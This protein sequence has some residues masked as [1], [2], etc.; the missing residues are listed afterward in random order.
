MANNKGMAPK[1]SPMMQHYLSMK[2]DYPDT[3][4]MYR[5]GDFYE[6]FF[7]DALEVSKLLDLTLTGRDCGLKERAPMCGVPYHAADNYIGKLVKLGKKV[8]I[9]EQLSAPGDQKGMVKR[10]VIRVITPGTVTSD[11]L[12]DSTCNNY[13]LS[14]FINNQSGAL[15][16]LDVSTGEMKVEELDENGLNRIEDFILSISPSEIIG[17]S[18]GCE[19]IKYSETVQTGKLPKPQNYYNYAFDFDNAAKTLRE[20]YSIYN[21]AA[22][23]MEDARDAVC[24]A[25]ALLNYIESTQKRTLS[26]IMTPRLMRDA[27]QMFLDY[28]TKRNLELT[29]TLTDKS[30]IGSLLWVL[31]K[32]KTNMGGR[33]LRRWIQEP[34]QNAEEIVFRQTAVGELVKNN[35]LRA[36]LDCVL[37]GIRDVERLCNKL[38]Y[39]SINPRE[40]LSVAYSLSQIP[41]LKKLLSKAKTEYLKQINGRLDPLEPI[42]ELI[43]KAINEQAPPTLKDGGVIQNG[44]HEELDG[45]RL[46]RSNAKKWLAEY[47]AR[48]R[49]STGLKTLKLGFNNVFGYYIE[50]SNSYLNLVP[51]SYERKQTLSTGERFITPELKKME[52]LILGAEEKAQKLEEKLYA[53]IKEVL[54]RAIKPLQANARAVAELDALFSFACSAYENAYVCPVI[55]KKNKHIL[56]KNGRHPVVEALKKA[57]EF[58]PNDTVMD[59]TSR[60]LIVT[61]PNMAGK[62][63]YMRQ[64][65][66]IVLMAH[67]GSFVPADS[68]EICLVDRIFTR[69]GASDNL[70]F[71]QS[72]FMVEMTEVANILNN[73]TARSLLILDEIGRGT[74][75]LDGLS[76]AWAIVEHVSLKL[77]AKTLFATHY[78]ELSELETVI[79]DLK[80]YHVLIKEGK[81]GIT[82]LYKIA[83]GGASKSFGIEVASLAGVSAKVIERAKDIMKTLEESHALSGG[84]HEKITANA[85]QDAIPIDQMGFFAEENKVADEIVSILEDVHVDEMTPVQALTL[86]SDLKKKLPNKKTKGN[87][88]K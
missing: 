64:V 19:R 27:G 30:R 33:C 10:D 55:S 17:N 36:E 63:T 79:P 60:T 61:G 62:S 59:D 7:E 34:L 8:S 84:F 70:A 83:R 67:M 46:A 52:E 28:N 81:D 51:Y 38:A 13:I 44:Y 35:S 12:L 68:A 14:I 2:K 4:L 77:K 88:S 23:G 37:G 49:E 87:R 26:H 5:L 54:A 11:E 40:C 58:V 57:N 78:H 72:T 65:A 85:S 1:L 25:G 22:I 86:L 39:N 48:E 53:D 18:E 9:C 56:I 45:Y 41:T 43:K 82:F 66:L 74:S 50:V 29:E 6:M 76:I 73:A 21:L 3:V 16:W 20:F 15:C 47:E 75:T 24:A 42:R 32:T 71:G 80:N 31:D 69:I